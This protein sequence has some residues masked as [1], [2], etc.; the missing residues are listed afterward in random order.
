LSQEI[1]IEIDGRGPEKLV[2]DLPETD[3]NRGKTAG[4]PAAHVIG[5]L[6]AEPAR[7]TKRHK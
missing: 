6:G 7:A 1:N 3:P 5:K 4:R 2:G